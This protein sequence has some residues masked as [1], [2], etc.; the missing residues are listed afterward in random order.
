MID[1]LVAS[2][3]SF[4]LALFTVS[5]GGVIGRR[6]GMTATPRLF[7]RGGRGG[8]EVV[9]YFGGTGLICRRALCL[10]HCGTGFGHASKETTRVH[11]WWFCA[12]AAWVT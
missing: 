2:V 11:P 3:L 12:L 6:Y 9:S 8:R 10:H 7:G 5:A 1:V 4:T